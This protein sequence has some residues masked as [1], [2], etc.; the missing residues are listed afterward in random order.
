VPVY[1]LQAEPQEIAEDHSLELQN[2]SWFGGSKHKANKYYWSKEYLA[3]SAKDKQDDL[4]KEITS[5]TS[6]GKFPSVAGLAGIFVES[7]EP[8]FTGEGDAM[9]A[10]TLFGSRSKL[11]H[12]V[13]TVGKVK[14]ISEPESSYSGIFKGA[15][16]G[17]VRFSSAAAPSK[18]QPL[19]PGLGLKFLRDGIDSANLVSMWGVEGQP[20]DWD[21]FSN[22][23][24]THIRAAPLGLNPLGAV[25][26]KFSTATDFIQEVGLSDFAEFDQYGNQ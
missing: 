14:F 17:L 20:N 1:F 7:M 12:S 3:K 15:N 19:A 22:I 24:F 6:S 2:L 4:W 21:F 26:K 11:I 13:G 10:G 23:F 25:A 16:Y 8:S 5:D 9:P 18:S